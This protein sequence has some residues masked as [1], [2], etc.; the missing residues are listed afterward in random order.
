MTIEHVNDRNST[1]RVT[2][3]TG[4]TSTTDM[5]DMAGASEA[6]TRTRHYAGPTFLAQQGKVFFSLGAYLRLDGVADRAE[7]GDPYGK[8]WFRTL[9]GV[10]L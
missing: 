2:T 6:P 1:N 5:N 10:E 8:V 7:V 3:M 9:I 4:G